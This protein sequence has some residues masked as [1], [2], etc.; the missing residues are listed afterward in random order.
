MNDKPNVEMIIKEKRL[1]NNCHHASLTSCCGA[2][3][4][5]PAGGALGKCLGKEG[6][7]FINGEIHVTMSQ[8]HGMHG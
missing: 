2:E 7:A 6:T 3:A 8:K 4:V 5:L 1:K